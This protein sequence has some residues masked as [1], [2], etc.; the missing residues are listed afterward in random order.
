MIP[1][2]L[3]GKRLELGTDPVV[4][5]Q[6]RATAVDSRVAARP[7]SRTVSHPGGGRSELHRADG[8]R[9]RCLA[10]LGCR[11]RFQRRRRS[12]PRSRQLR[13]RQR[14]RVVRRRRRDIRPRDQPRRRHQSRL[15]RGRRLQRRLGP[16]PRGVCQSQRTAS[17]SWCGWETGGTFGLADF[18]DAG[19]NP[20]SVAVGDFDGD[21][22]LD[23]VV[24]NRGS[25]DVSVLLGDGAGDFGP[26]TA[27][28]AGGGPGT[29]PSGTSM[30]TAI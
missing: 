17:T 13:L 19:T 24:A 7:G 9:G 12:R 18:H 15:G 8:L 1:W 30:G 16:R 4:P 27:F 29:S 21:S 26:A 22:N 10:R 25:D 2:P 5:S 6:C 23:L 14:L 3:G 20:S 11:G 28:A